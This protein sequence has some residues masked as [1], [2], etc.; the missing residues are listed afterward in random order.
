V[1]D[2]TPAAFTAHVS[3]RNLNDLI[4]LQQSTADIDV[5]LGGGTQY[6]TPM[7]RGKDGAAP[8]KGRIDGRHLLDEMKEKGYSVVTT[9]DELKAD[10]LKTPVIGLFAAKNLEFEVDRVAAD[11]P[12]LSDMTT[13]ALRLLNAKADKDGKGFFL[14]VEASRIDNCSHGNDGFCAVYETL[15]WNEAVKVARA[16][17]ATHPGRFNHLPCLCYQTL[18]LHSLVLSTITCPAFATKHSLFFFFLR[19]FPHLML[20]R[21]VDH[22]YK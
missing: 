22:V 21:H 9:P 1:T 13:T 19:S 6:F 20:T 14:L 2:A 17:A 7:E 4:A 11:Q 5:I 15:E 8:V 12:S 18:T 3:H 10:A 16:F